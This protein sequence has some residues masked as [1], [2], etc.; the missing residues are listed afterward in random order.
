MKRFCSLLAVLVIG[1]G[2]LAGPAAAAPTNVE[3]GVDVLSSNANDPIAIEVAEDGRVIWIEREGAVNVLSPD[4]TQVLAGR[5]PV[6]SDQCVGAA[7]APAGP[8]TVKQASDGCSA[9][10]LAGM[11]ADEAATLT[12]GNQPGGGAGSSDVGLNEGGLM[13]LLLAPDFETSHRIYL[14]WSVAGTYDTRTKTGEWRL[15]TYELD[16]ETNILDLGSE[17]ILWT[18]RTEW[19]HFAHYGFGLEWMPD[20]TILMAVGDD[21]SYQAN[22]GY[23]PRDWRQDYN[24]AETTSQNPANHRGK[25]LRLMPDGSV[26]DGVTALPDGTVPAA[27]PF[28]GE[29]MD[30]PYICLSR[31]LDRGGNGAFDP[32]T[33]TCPDPGWPAIEYDPYVYSMGW[34]Q[35]WRGVVLPDG[36]AVYG[37]V[38]PDAGSDSATRGRAGREEINHV[39]PGGGTNYGWPR[40][41]GSPEDATGVGGNTY[42]YINVNSATGATSGELSCAGFDAPI[43]WYGGSSGNPWGAMGTSGAKTSEPLVAY[44]ADVDG[45]LALPAQFDNTVIMTEW[46]RNWVLGI[47][48]DPETYELQVRDAEGRPSDASWIRATN[49]TGGNPWSGVLDAEI[50][51][52]GAVYA[53]K[54]GNSYRNNT[55]SQILRMRCAGCSDGLYGTAAATPMSVLP[56]QGAGATGL[57]VLVLAVVAVALAGRR[58]R[59]VV[60]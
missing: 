37:E 22:G 25:L 43:L 23:G 15:A 55:G 34:K 30:N 3:V 11:A 32:Y 21:V 5:L 46:N 39:P 20:G 49:A 59:S 45:P 28:I 36:S 57:V 41:I 16:P 7:F 56:A 40:C 47:P 8:Y 38:A 27:N 44:T 26:P 51:P 33:Q 54:H 35:P 2:L 52:D 14:T 48:F 4:G 58:R 18:T 9:A 19:D 42:G 50:G 1:F 12:P 53:V 29:T 31:T 10:A 17:E 6:S 60:L 24:N 13:G